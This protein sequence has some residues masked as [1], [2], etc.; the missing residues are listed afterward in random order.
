[1]PILSYNQINDL[2]RE[3]TNA[4]YQ[5]NT[6]GSGELSE[7]DLNVMLS[8]SPNYPMLW[9]TPVDVQTANNTINYG[10]NLLVLD[11]VDKDKSN[12]QQV[13][14]DNL[15]IALDIVRILRYTEDEF[16]IVD[17]PVITPFAGR[18]SEWV[19]GWAIETNIQ[20]D[21]QQNDCDIPYDG[22]NLTQLLQNFAG[23]GIG[24]FG[25][26]DLSG[27]TTIINIE[28]N[29]TTA[30]S[31]TITGGTYFSA[32]STLELYN[33]SGGTIQITGITSGGSGVVPNLQEVT[34]V[35][36]QTDNDI[37]FSGD[38]VGILFDNGAKLQ[39]GTT[40]GGLGGQKGIAQICSNAYELKWEAGRLYA[41]EQDGFTIRE[42]SYQFNNTPTA[43]DDTDKGYVIGSRWI[44]DNG[45][46]YL[47]SDNTQGAAVWNLVSNISGNRTEIAYFD[48]NN[49]L[50]GDSFFTR[51]INNNF[52]TIIAATDGTDS[53]KL[54]ASYNEITIEVEDNV[55]GLT[56]QNQFT[57]TSSSFNVVNSST[58]EFSGFDFN[59]AGGSFRYFDSV[60]G[61][62]NGY[63][64]LQNQIGYNVIRNGIQYTYNFP[65]SPFVAGG[66]LTDPNG[67]G[68]LQWDLPQDTG[69][70][71]GGIPY[72][73]NLS[74][75]QTPYRE[76]SPIATTA[77]EQS[78]GVSIANGATATIAEFLTPV[79]Y[80]NA[81]LLPGGIWTFHLHS[82]KNT[83]NASFEIFV[84]V[85]KRSS[86]GTETLL[87]TTDSEPVLST[88][89]TINMQICDV[90][91]SGTPLLTSDRI[92]AKVIATNTSNQTHTITLFTEGNQHYSYAT[93]T[94]SVLGLTC[95]TLSGCSTIQTIQTNLS[96][97]YDKSGGTISGDVRVQPT[98]S[99]N[100]KPLTS[101]S[102]N[103]SESIAFYGIA[104]KGTNAYGI[105]CDVSPSAEFYTITNGIGGYFNVGGQFSEGEPT[106]KYSLQLIDGTQGLNK[107]LTSVTSDGKANWRDTI[108][109]SAITANTLNISTIP[110]LNNSPTQILTR[111]SSTGRIEYTEPSQYLNEA[112]TDQIY[113][114]GFDG[115]VVMDGTNTYAAFTTKVGSAYTLTRTIYTNNLTLSNNSTLNPNGFGIYVKGTLAFNDF[116]SGIQSNGNN[117]NNA[118]AGTAGTGGT[119]RAAAA[120]NYII[121][122]CGTGGGSGGNS[123]SAAGNITVGVNYVGGIGGSG[124]FGYPSGN[125]GVGTT[126]ARGT[127]SVTAGILQQPYSNNYLSHSL[128]F[129]SV[130]MFAG[131]SGAGGQCG[132]NAGGGV[133]GAGGGGGTATRGVVIIANTI[134]MTVGGGP[135]GNI[136]SQGGNGGTGGNAGGTN[137][138]GGG[139][140]GGGGGG[141]IYIL[142]NSLSYVPNN[143]IR[144]AGGAGGLGGTCI[145]TV[146]GQAQAGLRSQSGS[147]GVDGYIVIINPVTGTNTV[148]TGLY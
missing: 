100:N 110:T 145:G 52:E 7:A 103:S 130:Q 97:K 34:D 70:G 92:L 119:S 85:Y 147:N 53:A 101:I 93:T 142:T 9:L 43:T 1:M 143:R 79:G 33:Q 115:D 146:N 22:L 18:Y 73:L 86:G 141:F 64:Y 71:G 107:V 15:Q 99:V 60:S 148:Y 17:E 37:S 127:V 105:Y 63:F 125:T 126:T 123:S 112:S 54:R 111:N 48:N 102:E 124:G 98:P 122:N 104:G 28:N 83:S 136:Q 27:C 6:F 114:S 4:H 69:T 30:L 39:K 82:N 113:G 144:A 59:G 67:D 81:T 44:L 84:E 55:N 68:N 40:D 134:D 31:N 87:F 121:M 47:C 117:G 12:E 41:M 32:T 10:I 29:L 120:T 90:Y 16:N 89:P 94:F 24:Q 95:E 62:S 129:G 13:L 36:N 45:D 2:F 56:N 137:A 35:G 116:N 133:Q 138:T 135:T 51:D 14:S 49:N 5:L 23:A 74:N 108:N 109:L 42:V 118:T 50:S 38:G 128:Y 58:G 77:A 88:S 78:S 91:F 96:N 106:N 140:G 3:I 26:D 8:D 46:V 132:I 72:F 25:C 11:I 76:F 57:P 66:I 131:H 61:L 19:A 75:S 20:V 80:P 21:F 65:Q 139:G